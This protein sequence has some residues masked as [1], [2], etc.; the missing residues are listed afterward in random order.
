MSK[1]S[2]DTLMQAAS[3]LTTDIAPERDLWPEIAATIDRPRPRRWQPMFAQA[4]AV[5]VLIASSSGITWIT[6]QEST[7]DGP[8]VVSP[9]LMFESASFGS[10]PL[11]PGFEDARDSLLAE[12]EME[13]AKLS[14]AARQNIE[15]N[16]KL[17]RDAITE[18]NIAL[19]AEPD[20]TL[21][22]ERLL[23]TYQEELMLL[24]RMGGLTRN[25][26]RRND[27]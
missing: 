6:M 12:L 23:K 7:S 5:V 25:V 19:E 1:E 8:V 21:L 11:G 3:R 18:M 15:A 4:A 13:L 10:Q 2:D 17:I 16:L 27:I 24:R 9:D 20:N 14:P 22:Q 26:M